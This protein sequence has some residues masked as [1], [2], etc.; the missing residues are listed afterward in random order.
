MIYPDIF[1][2][3]VKAEFPD[4]K[5]LHDK[6]ESG[7][8]LVGAMLDDSA[9]MRMTPEQ[10]VKAFEDGKEQVVKSAAQSVL[11]RRALH[12]EWCVLYNQQVRHARH[13]GPI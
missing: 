1:K 3:K 11:T 8:A 5:E 10:I 6:L 12:Q 7:A 2:Q 9:V 13:P 4:W